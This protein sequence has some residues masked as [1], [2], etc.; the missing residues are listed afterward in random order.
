LLAALAALVM[1]IPAA[2]VMLTVII[3][4]I[5]VFLKSVGEAHGFSAWRALAAAVLSSL[6]IFVPVFVLGLLAG[7]LV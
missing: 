5:V 2:I 6:M 1:A 3:W 4:Y 7:A